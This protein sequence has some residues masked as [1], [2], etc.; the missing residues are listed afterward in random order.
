MPLTVARPVNRSSLRERSWPKVIVLASL[1]SAGD[2]SAFCRANTC[3]TTPVLSPAGGACA[4]AGWEED[5]A[6][7]RNP[8]LPLWWRSACLDYSV[9]I[10]EAP[11][12]AEAGIGAVKK[13]FSAWTTRTCDGRARTSIDVHVTGPVRGGI[14]EYLSEGPNKNFILF[15]G[16]KWPHKTIAEIDTNTR[17]LEL[18]L[19]TLTYSPETGEIL[20]ADIE[21]NSAEYD[22]GLVNPKSSPDLYDLQTV[23]TH[24][25]GHSLG[26]AHSPDPLSA[27]Y[28]RGD[29][30]SIAKRKL[31]EDDGRGI[32]AAYPPD[33][34]RALGI[35]ASQRSH[36]AGQ[37][38]EPV[39]PAAD[40]A[41]PPEPTRKLTCALGP[42]EASR[43]RASWLLLCVAGLLALR[44]T[45]R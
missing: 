33:G 23:L 22:L 32:C 14:A 41:P 45:N 4:P 36:R 34:R 11:V 44:R 10:T 39:L 18:A 13:A 8:A 27:M 20:D 28:P 3:K 31:T 6:E 9:D 40:P 35:T 24:E 25:V 29:S 42:H 26:F 21:V 38:C 30:K 16:D 17:S 15:H 43:G 12:S 2:A 37:A 1:L 7:D 5:C 19:T